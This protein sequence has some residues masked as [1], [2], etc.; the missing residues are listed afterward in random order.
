MTLPGVANVDIT[1]MKDTR[2]PMLGESG[3]VEFRWELFNLFNRPN[4]G[5]PALT[6]FD[7]TGTLQT[8][9]GEITSTKDSVPSRQIQFALKIVF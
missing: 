1:F 8:D 6:V 9:A 2:L 5:S 4:F 3:S 7:R